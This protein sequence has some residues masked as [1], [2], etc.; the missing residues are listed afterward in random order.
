MSHYSINKVD[1]VDAMQ[2][3]RDIFPDA[4]AN[5]MNFVIF[6]TSG[7]HGS[8]R[9]IED[10]ED[11]GLESEEEPTITFLVI[12]PRI[13]ETSYGVCQPITP[14]DFTFL[15]KLRETSREVMRGL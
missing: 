3:L 12:K 9:K 4:E 11:Q 14:E 13:V 2:V 1:T 6:S 5:E 15:K 8:Y 7:V 10:V